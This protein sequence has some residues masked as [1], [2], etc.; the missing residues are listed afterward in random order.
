MIH[1]DKNRTDIEVSDIEMINKMR[2]VLTVAEKTYS[3]SKQANE[4]EE[5]QEF[6]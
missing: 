5:K 3:L 2:I 6:Q 4:V 1:K